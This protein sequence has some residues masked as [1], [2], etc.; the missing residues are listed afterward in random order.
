MT[1]HTF[2]SLFESSSISLPKKQIAFLNRYV[3]GTWKINP[4]T[5]L[6]DVEGNVIFVK[7]K[8]VT[9]PVKFGRVSGTFD[10]SDN[11][12]VS[13]EGAP[14][15][16]EGSFHCTANQLV[17]LEGAPQKVEGSF[18]CTANQLVSLEG[19][20]QEVRG[21]FHCSH[22]KLTSLV[23]APQKVEGSFY[24]SHN[25]LVSLE[26]APKE[27]GGNF[28]CSYNQLVSLEGAPEKVGDIFRCGVF[29]IPEKKWGFEGWMNVLVTGDEKARSLIS[30]ILSP[31][32]INKEIQ[33]NPEEMMMRLKGVWNSPGFA[34]IRKEI[35]IPDRYRGEMNTL[36][37]LSD[38]GF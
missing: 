34:S 16:V 14:Q 7:K 31:L 18:Y 17:S 36:G 2:S 19:A 10:C 24:C 4:S 25:Q 26:G 13:L 35:V 28:W 22:N 23:G 21:K 3:T 9:V 20:P 12:L 27:V 38:L 5:G 33:K 37:D 32:Y 30:T 1:L 8:M 6:V 11:Q 15:K 29:E